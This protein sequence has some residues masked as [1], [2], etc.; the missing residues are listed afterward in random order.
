MQLDFYMR[1]NPGSLSTYQAI[2]L[3]LVATKRNYGCL[4]SFTFSVF[5]MFEREGESP[6]LHARVIRAPGPDL[7]CF[8]RPS[9]PA[10]GGTGRFWLQNQ[11]LCSWLIPARVP[12]PSVGPFAVASS[13]ETYPLSPSS[14]AEDEKT[15]FPD[16]IETCG[17]KDSSQWVGLNYGDFPPLLCEVL[18]HC[19]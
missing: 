1:K 9:R 13:L 7:H 18:L 2:I 5:K 12:L 4:K 16:C 15:R 17:K 19:E 14:R 3:L 10:G 6:A 8:P 11:T